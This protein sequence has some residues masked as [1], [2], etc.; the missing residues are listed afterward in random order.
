[1]AARVEIGLE[2]LLSDPVLRQRL[3]G[4]RVGLIA[5]PASVLPDLTPSA[6]VLL[7]AGV[8]LTALFA[9]E[10]GYTGTVADGE[11]VT[12]TTDQVTGLPVFSLYGSGFAPSPEGLAL[13]DLLVYDMQDIG[14]RFY[15][16]ISTLVYVLQ[17]AAELGMEVL[18]CDRPNPIGGLA[19][20]GPG[21]EPAYRSFIG[22]ADIPIRHGMTA[23]EL[24]S[25]FN[26]RLPKPAPLTVIPMRGWQRGIYFDDCGLPWVAT[27]PAMPSVQTALV[28]LGTC[29]FEGINLSDGRG[30]AQPFELT[31]AP[32][33]DAPALAATL[34]K[35]QLSGVRFR[36]AWFTPGGGKHKG[37]VCAGV[38]THVTERAT[39]RPVLSGLSVLQACLRQDPERAA[40]LPESWEGLLPHFD[41]LAGGSG[42][43]E[44]LLTDVAVAEIA[45]N[46]RAFEDKFKI[47]SE[48][49]YLYEGGTA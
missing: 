7:A 25:F 4:K 47:D 16:Y 21:V 32:W 17:A 10:H 40:F 30:T 48:H 24:A 34:N 45:Q 14:C 26:D 37:L 44:A 43:R 31:G 49:Y 20:E 35:L 18:V 22:I 36:A 11:A 8:N 39:F 6:Q 29:F 38:Q 2:R 42:I 41:L 9:P 15:T 13:V 3:K 12:F 5:H 28:Y 46:W 1:M 23:G 33:L 19:V 27:S